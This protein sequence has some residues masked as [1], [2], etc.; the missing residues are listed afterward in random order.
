MRNIKVEKKN[1]KS[2]GK[3]AK[4]V[5]GQ[6][7]ENML[8]LNYKRKA[9]WNH[10][11]IH[12]PAIRLGKRKPKIL[13]AHSVSKIIGKQH[14]DVTMDIQYGTT[15][16]GKSP[17]KLH[18]PNNPTVRNLFQRYTRWNTSCGT[19]NKA[20]RPYSSESQ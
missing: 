16:M 9:N 10:T 6:F 2:I 19:L 15:P 17:A 3:W 18:R 1:S 11:L 8:K 20:I 7:S 13:V 4:Y 12:F 5:N 14:S